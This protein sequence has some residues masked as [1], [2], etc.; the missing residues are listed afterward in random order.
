MRH[1]CVEKIII[2]APEIFTEIYR[3]EAR[4]RCLDGSATA[5]R[6]RESGSIPMSC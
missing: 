1:V 5:Q 3:V 2:L 6:L 4:Y